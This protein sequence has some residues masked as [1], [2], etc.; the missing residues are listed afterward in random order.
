MSPLFWPRLLLW[1]AI[2]GAL[3]A[4][5]ALLA[6]RHYKPLLEAEKRAFAEFRGGVEAL[7][8][9]AEKRTAETNAANEKR[10]RDAD[11]EAGKTKRDLAALYDAYGRLRD[12]RISAGSGVLPPTAAA[13]PDPD[14]ICFSRAALD[15]GLVEAD[16]VLQAGAL[17]LLRR[18]DAGIGD[19]GVIRAWAAGR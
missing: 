16:G 14:R 19:L 10:K 6:A 7:G 8:R 18:G 4:S 5:G 15:R 3:V 13:A 9:A 1:A 2:A 17:P 12:Q 11:A